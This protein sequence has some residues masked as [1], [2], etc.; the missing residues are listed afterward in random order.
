MNKL[1]RFELRKIL[2][3]KS[4]YVCMAISLGFLLLTLVTAKVANDALEAIGQPTLKLSGA[5]FA[6]SGISNASIG[7]ISAIFV[8]IYVCED[9]SSGTL[10]TILAKGNDRTKIFFSKYIIT[11]CAVIFWSILAVLVSFLL[12][13]A[14]YG[15]KEAFKDNLVAIIFGQ[16]FGVLAYHS[17]YFMISYSFGKIAPA[18]ALNILGPLG[19]NLLLNFGDTIIK[20]DSFKLSDY[21]I[22]GIVGNFTASE[23]N[24]K[25]IVSGII[26]LIV[27]CAAGIVAGW[28]IARRKEI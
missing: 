24:N 13:T 8:A 1:L 5:F 23:T 14:L 6:K 17:L 4:F 18:I 15:N 21:W 26:L 11:V 27:Y 25:L 19:V 10:K 7:M 16:L 3:S 9:F 12:G 22:D 2:R 28:L 20:S